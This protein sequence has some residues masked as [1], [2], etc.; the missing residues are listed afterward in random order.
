MKNPL[1]L[2]AL[3]SLL[4]GSCRSTRSPA[5]ARFVEGIILHL[6]DVY[7]ITPL[8]S[9]RV[10]GMARV[11]TI[12]QQLLAE[13]PNV[14]TVLDGDFLS[15]SALG[16]IA[17]PDG[18]PMKGRQMVDVMNTLGVDLVNFGN[19]EFDLDGTGVLLQQ[20]IDESRFAWVSS[21]VFQKNGTVIGPFS[22]QITATRR[23]YFPKNFV[24]TLRN[25]PGDSARIGFFA[26]CL[27]ANKTNY[28]H[29]DDV[30]TTARQQTD[31]LRPRTEGIV[32]LTHI[33][34]RDDSLLAGQLSG[35]AL[36]I[37][38]HDHTSLRFRHHGVVVAKADANAKSVY[39]HRLRYDPTTRQLG[40]RSELRRVTDAI[41]SEPKTD[42]VVRY[43]MG[44]ARASL[45]K[46][47]F[48]AD[49]TVTTLFESL[50]GTD[51]ANR[52]RPTA[53]GEVIAEAMLAAVPATDHA[54]LAF[55]NSG[56]IRIDDQLAGRVTEFDLFRILPYGSPFVTVELP[57]VALRAVLDE[58]R[59]K[60]GNGGYLQG[61]RVS[62]T[63]GDWSVAGQ[64]LDTGRVY[65]AVVSEYLL[66][67]N[68]ADNLTLKKMPASAR[69]PVSSINQNDP[70]D[71]RN[72]IRKALRAYWRG[73]GKH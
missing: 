7:E 73:S 59:S 63:N 23:A 18:K 35:V 70:A 64:P 12:R 30:M 47:G 44:V 15:P 28:V 66:S 39:I 65:R 6:N 46:A 8:D 9:G 13:N 62:R 33:N 16:F 60:L 55:F 19:H 3:G 49:S 10:G 72:D 52:Y 68:Q 27:D 2:L 14:L 20:R 67:E 48:A 17:G 50:D 4:I 41:P 61:C 31:S 37:G 42:S 69:Q 21:N 25:A 58:G 34:V 22:K 24:W 40:V 71:L 5:P 43:W 29:Y 1:L 36:L 57:G 38:G 26:V 45:Q 53:L 32:G 51:A 11:A 54:D 56:S